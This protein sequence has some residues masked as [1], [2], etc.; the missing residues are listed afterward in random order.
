[1]RS[2]LQD[3]ISQNRLIESL[4][5]TAFFDPER[6]SAITS[7]TSFKAA[8]NSVTNIP[9]FVSIFGAESAYRIVL[10]FVYQY[11]RRVDSVR[12]DDAE[13]E[14]L[15]SDFIAETQEPF[16]LMRGVANLRNFDTEAYPIDLGDGITISG[17]SQRELTSLG[18]D[19]AVWQRIT[20]DWRMGGASSFVLIAESSVAKEPNNL[21]FVDSYTPLLKATRA[22]SALRLIG[23]GSVSIGPMWVVRPARF[24]VG[25][26]GGLRQSGISFPVFGSRYTCGDKVQSSYPLIYAALA[27]LESEGYGKSPGNLSVALRSFMGTYDRWPPQNDW[28]LLELITALE[29]VLGISSELTFR[30]SFRVASL[31]ASNDGER[32]YLLTLVREFYDT[33]STI[34]HGSTLG[35]KHRALLAR[36]DEL[37]TLVRKL[38]KALVIFA[39]GPSSAYYTK[40]FW[41]KQFDAALLD[42]NEREKLRAE[43]GLR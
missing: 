11:F 36:L 35:T 20:D 29:A 39:A 22:M 41:S 17:R 10:Q 14:A 42:A 33:R 13:F 25:V 24:D 37:R 31:L 12:Y 40:G 8:S 5:G 1:M 7:Q 18:F 15:W 30:L 16:W 28:Q 23:E 4:R 9:N 21:I 34:I 27:K 2:L 3:V 43:L 6:D 38:L 32:T 19:D 26:G